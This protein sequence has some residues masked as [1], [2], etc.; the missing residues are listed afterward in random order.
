LDS[1]GNSV[2]GIQVCDSLSRALDLHLFNLS[3]TAKSVIRLRFTGAE[4]NSSRLRRSEEVKQLRESGGAIQLCQLQGNLIF[5]SC[6]VLVRTVLNSLDDLHYLI[7][8][9]KHVLAIDESASRLLYHLQMRFTEQGRMMVFSRAGH[10]P[11]LRR[12]FKAKLGTQF[13]SGFHSFEDNDLALEWCE[14][15][16]LETKVAGQS[17]GGA[18]GIES[19]ELFRGLEP[20]EIQVLSNLLEHRTCHRGEVLVQI[21]AEAG[22]IFF[23]HRGLASITIPLPNGG[24]R[25]LGVFSPGMAFGEVAMLDGAPRSAVVIAETEMECHL[26]KREDFES[27]EQTHPHIK[28]T[29]L[30]NMALGIARLLRKATREVSVFDY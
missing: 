1:R 21:G 9:L 19:Y 28:V 3:A 2:R 11:P 12:Y 16:W 13:Q 14:N 26:L 30:K 17:E 10:L 27:L 25:R 20:E 5:A 18:V 7:L 15:R 29:L 6:E 24:Q 23:I 4:V 22:E 8:D